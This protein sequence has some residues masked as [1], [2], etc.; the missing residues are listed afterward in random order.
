MHSYTIITGASSGIGLALTK[1]LAA[2]NTPLILACRNLQ[3]AEAL[4]TELHSTAPI[5]IEKLELSSFQSVIEFSQR[6]RRLRLHALVNNAGASYTQYTLS[7]D[8]Y[9]LSLATNCLAPSLLCLALA[10]QLQNNGII[11]NTVS[12]THRFGKIADTFPHIA[13]KPYAQLKNYSNAKLALYLFTYKLW[14]QRGQSIRIHAYDPGIVNTGMI[15]M[16]RWYD[17]LADVLFRPLIR[18]PQSAAKIAVRALEH[19]DSGLIFKSRSQTPM[20]SSIAEHADIERVWE[21]IN[22]LY[23]SLFMSS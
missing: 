7:N 16:K 2:R 22:S 21:A 11:L 1:A 6:V 17:P 3:K 4:K 8:G 23:S 19:A 10:E 5:L 20:P 12:L 18:K 9:E 14:Q 15:S 13:P